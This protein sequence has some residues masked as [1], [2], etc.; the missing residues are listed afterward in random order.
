AAAQ[1]WGV[2]PDVCKAARGEV[3]GPA[4]QRLT[5][6][7]LAA[8]AMA[9][10]VPA[11]VTLKPPAEFRLVGKSTRRLDNPAKVNGTA[12]FGSDVRLP[13]MLYAAL[14]QCPVIG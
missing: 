10:P 14:A 13:G 1:R 5:Y 8:D 12:T 7:A 6:G 11:R 3:S 9:L 2:S 4:G